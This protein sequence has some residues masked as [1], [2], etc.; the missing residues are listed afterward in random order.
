MANNWFQFKEFKIQQDKCG[1]KVSTD[2]CIQGAVAADFL[3]Q[4]PELKWVLDIGAGTG[5]LSLMLV[6]KRNDLIIDALEI[7][8]NS[9][10]QAK[11]NFK[12]SKWDSQLTVHHCA[13]QNWEKEDSSKYDFIICNPPF[14]QNHLQS[15]QEERNTA[16]HNVSLSSE[17][18]INQVV[19]QLKDFGIFCLLFP[20]T[21]WEQFA[22][23]AQRKGLFI[24]K[25]IFIQPKPHL[26]FNRIIAFF[27]KTKSVEIIYK[28]LIIYKSEKE[29]TIEFK[30]L[31]KDYYLYL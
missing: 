10:E 23:S 1:M 14:F 15:E 18:L 25:L 19:F 20:K 12:D 8:Q 11:E 24:S 31:L 28:T 21:G 16:R 13:I 17:D 6:Q 22:D 3:L 2:A 30:E 26:E 27:T 5:L 7:E 4:K 9:F 29:Y